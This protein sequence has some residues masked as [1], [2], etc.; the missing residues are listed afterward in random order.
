MEISF[1]KIWKKFWQSIFQASIVQWILAAIFAT[2]IWL[3]YMTCRVRINNYSV[4]QE[5]KKKPAV[6][7]FWHGRSLMLSPIVCVGGMR[8]YIMASKHKDGRLVA[9]L[10]RMFG[11]RHILGSSSIGAVSVLRQGLRV[12]KDGGYAICMSPDGPGGPS[13]RIKDGA[14]YFAQMSGCPIIPVCYTASRAWI[15]DRWD[16]FMLPKPFSKIICNVGDPIYI[17]RRASA[18]EFESERKKIEGI[19]VKQMWDMDAKFGY[20]PMPQDLRSHIYKRQRRAEKEQQRAAR[21][22][23]GKK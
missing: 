8:A 14:M 21:K 7:A 18:D 23:K 15:W 1:R 4:F 12:L 10:Q 3:I 6:F 16:K 2:F 5:F 19:M 17:N 13:L 9:K 22:S 11:L 20:A